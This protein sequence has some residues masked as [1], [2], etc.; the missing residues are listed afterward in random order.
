LLWLARELWTR[1]AVLVAITLGVFCLPTGANPEA[2]PVVTAPDLSALVLVGVVAV[3]VCAGQA[4]QWLSTGVVAA[5]AAL[6]CAA[7]LASMVA[8]DPERSVLGLVRY[9]EIFVAVPLAVALSIRDRADARLVLA[10]FVAVGLVQCVIAVNQVLTGTGASFG[11]DPV[12]AIGTFGAY[13]IMTMPTVVTFALLAALAVALE[14]TGATRRAAAVAGLFLIVPL[15]LSLSRGAWLS[16][17]VG[18]V[19]V[20]ALSSMRRLLLLASVAVLVGF[21]AFGIA[22]PDLGVVGARA[23]SLVTARETGPAADSSVRDRYRLWA[24]AIGMW[25]DNPIAGVGPRNFA[26]WRDSYAALDLSSFS[27]ISDPVGGYRRVQL[28][29][30]HNL[31]LLILSEQ[32]IVGMAAFLTFLLVLSVGAFRRLRARSDDAIVRALGIFALAVQARLVVNL[33]WSDPG[34][35]AGAL[36]QAVALG[37]LV[38][39]AGGAMTRAHAP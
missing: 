39:F 12:R 3:Q 37:L 21:I 16:A 30:P 10:A 36:F 26:L 11:G 34:G 19:A 6:G 1:P 29:S 13:D 15:A 28:E 18:V 7:L 22:R 8:T 23:S 38:W 31:Y 5:V 32:G 17:I 4:R 33:I 20:V 35:G 9:V 25:G 2:G 14:T 24:A 27:E